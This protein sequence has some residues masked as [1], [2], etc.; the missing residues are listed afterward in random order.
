M[1]KYYLAIQSS[2]IEE[3][4]MTKKIVLIMYQ[5]EKIGYKL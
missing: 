5:V 1:M 2:I 3:N 4:M